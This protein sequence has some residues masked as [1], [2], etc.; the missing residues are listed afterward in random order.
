[1]TTLPPETPP[2]GN[3][4]E[5][6]LLRLSIAVTVGLALANMAAGLW[7]GSRTIVF[8]GIYG[9]AD[10]VMTA[11]AL[12]VS[13]LIARGD[14]RRFQFGYWHLEPLLTAVNGTV[15]ALACAYGVLDGIGGLLH[16]GNRVAG[17]PAA[18][19]GLGNGIVSLGM[20][21]WLAPRVRRLDSQLL[22]TDMRA[23][24]I[25][26]VFGIG[27][28]IAFA[29]AG[30]IGG[31]FGVLWGRMAADYADPLI[32]ALLALVLLPLPIAQV[33]TAMRDI[34]QITPAALDAE[35]A[36]VAAAVATAHGFVDWRSHV[37]RSG[38]AQFI[39]IGL[40]A[41]PDWS[42]G[43]M[44]TLDAVREDIAA[45]LGGRDAGRWLTV[46]F[47]ADERWI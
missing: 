1:M 47:T 44:A 33:V 37:V 8:D 9:L 3:A 12:L 25:G 21:A 18:L 26:G 14:D 28:A 35:V 27:I 40:L 38:R 15:L 11:L 10:T 17:G 39:E 4:A 22:H 19:I 6:A 36:A 2:E 31:S 32:L 45:R 34:L 23:W 5:Q 43:S 30:A 24:T 16:G 20:A 41:P 46:D 7:L 13:S 42:P 29:V